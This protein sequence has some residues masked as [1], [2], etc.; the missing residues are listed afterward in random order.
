M[1]RPVVQILVVV[2]MI[3]GRTLKTEEEKG[4]TQTEIGRG[5]VGPELFG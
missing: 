5:L 4:F 3:Q 2:A 1:K